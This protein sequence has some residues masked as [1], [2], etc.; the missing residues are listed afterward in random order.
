MDSDDSLRQDVYALPESQRIRVR[1]NF[2][3]FPDYLS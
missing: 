1:Y 2:T 3:I